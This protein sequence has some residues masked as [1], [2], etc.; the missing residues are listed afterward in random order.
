MKH[1]P[2]T[3]TLLLP[4][5]KYVMKH[6]PIK[7]TLLLPFYYSH[8]TSLE[9]Y[10]SNIIIFSYKRRALKTMGMSHSLLCLY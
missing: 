8:K 4:F 3:F 9:L 1:R 7:I 5:L 10:Q 6:R 2:I